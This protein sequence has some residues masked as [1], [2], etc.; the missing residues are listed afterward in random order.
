[1][2]RQLL[3]ASGD[4]LVAVE[5][6]GTV[7]AWSAGAESTFGRPADQ[8]V[9]APLADQLPAALTRAVADA[10]RVACD[11]TST[12]F[13][14][15]D[16]TGPAPWLRVRVG[17]LLAHDVCIGATIAAEP[18]EAATAADQPTSTS[19]QGV[20]ATISQAMLRGDPTESIVATAVEGVSRALGAD[21]VAFVELRRGSNEHTVLA[22]TGGQATGPA[23]ATGPF[24]SHLAF[25]IQSHR[26]IVVRDFSSERRFDRG[27][28]AGEQAAV[29]GLCLPV[30]WPGGGE[31]AL[32]VHSA[33][34]HL[35]MATGDVTFVQSAANL[36]ALTLARRHDA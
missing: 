3:D 24:G 30:Q 12:S 16:G 35:A 22:A 26:P 34:D 20:I 11:G 27:P 6:D 9:G 29:S 36:C 31:G 19:F 14:V 23:P 17:P 7:L 18:A 32:C 15:H 33:T 1:V 21:H 4:A 28:L 5:R 2:A 25:A 8:A 13:D 10:V